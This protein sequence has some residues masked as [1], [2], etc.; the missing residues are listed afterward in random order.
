[1]ETHGYTHYWVAYPLAGM[2]IDL[3]I[4]HKDHYYCIDF[5]GYPGASQSALPLERWKLLG[6]LRLRSFTLPYSQWRRNKSACEG[7]LLEFLQ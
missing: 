5:V 3:V 4:H 2:S 1:L 6:R 7:L